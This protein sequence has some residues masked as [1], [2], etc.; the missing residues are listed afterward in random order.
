MAHES[1]NGIDQL[2][3]RVVDQCVCGGGYCGSNLGVPHNGPE[4]M[5]GR[6]WNE[7]VVKKTQIHEL[8]QCD[9][10]VNFHKSSHIRCIWRLIFSFL[11]VIDGNF[12][13][14]NLHLV[15]KEPP[16]I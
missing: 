4:E 2:S 16:M 6:K 9:C 5:L 14:L 10:G 15:F 11:K 7:E 13:K 12:V 3:H 8:C 1:A